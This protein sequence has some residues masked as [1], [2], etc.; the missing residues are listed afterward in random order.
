M[1]EPSTSIE[2]LDSHDSDAEIQEITDTEQL[3][4]TIQS[5]RS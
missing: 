4:L 1:S 5:E 2:I 3:L